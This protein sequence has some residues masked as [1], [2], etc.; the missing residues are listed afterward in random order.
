MLGIKT[1]LPASQVVA[2]CMEKGMLCLTAKDR[3]RLL[4]AL[5]IP[6]E[7]LLRAADILLECCR[8]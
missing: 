4:P 2:R 8:P 5:N 7:L 3:V 1:L 6:D